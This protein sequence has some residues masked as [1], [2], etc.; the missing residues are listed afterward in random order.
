[1]LTLLSKS[2]SLRPYYSPTRVYVQGNLALSPSD[3]LYNSEHGLAS[4]SAMLDESLFYEGDSSRS[5][6][7]RPEH[8]RGY[9][10][11]D[12]WNAQKSALKKL[13][14]VHNTYNSYLPTPTNPSNNA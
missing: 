4:S 7:L 11:V 12:A 10:I 1:M 5:I 3:I 9:G 2:R 6:E 8:R 13:N 14:E